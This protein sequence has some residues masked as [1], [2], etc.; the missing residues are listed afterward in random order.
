MADK[1]RNLGANVT[2]TRDSDITLSPRERTN[3]VLNAYGNSGDVLVISNH[4]NAGGGDGAEVI[5]ALRGTDELPNLIL[6]KL[7]DQGQNI[8]KAYTR[9]LP[10]D[11]EKDYY[12]MLRDTGNTDA[13]IIEYGFLDSN[14]DDVYQLKNN[15]QK[16]ADAAVN[17]IA[18]YLNL[19]KNNTV[20]NTYTVRAGDTLWSI[21][22]K[23]DI[24]VNDIKR[25]N[26][27]TNNLLTIGQILN[28]PS[29]NQNEYIVKSGDTLYSIAKKNNLT[30]DELKSLNDLS[31]NTL[32][33][34]QRLIIS[35]KFNTNSYTVKPGDTLYSIAQKYNTT[36]DQIKS[37]N[38]LTSNFLSVNQTLKI[39]N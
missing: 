38:N 25:L 11:P 32:K 39:S 5:Y 22:K 23:F 37:L 3:R 7:A 24:T 36:V 26:S 30:V 8:R 20:E 10:S 1:L 34:G 17:A 18:E 35:S 21:A 27:L 4:I 15:W 19:G 31:N 14:K 12:F 2:L 9:R 33:I 16:Y 13:I 28:I 29:F 6:E